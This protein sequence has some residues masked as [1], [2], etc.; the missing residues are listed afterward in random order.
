M[1]SELHPAPF[2]LGILRALPPLTPS[3]FLTGVS[4]DF[5]GEGIKQGG[6]I[7]SFAAALLGTEVIRHHLPPE[8]PFVLKSPSF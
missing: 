6:V 2:S 4:G 5:I 8:E 7:T 3:D 1:V